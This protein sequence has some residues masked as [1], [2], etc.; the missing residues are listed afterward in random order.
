MTVTE[1]ESEDDDPP[2]RQPSRKRNHN[3]DF[4]SQLSDHLD[5]DYQLEQADHD[6]KIIDQTSH[7]PEET[8][9]KKHR[10]R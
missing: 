1:S 6:E 4:S 8:P 9:S 10:R 3:L 2:R 7:S 5:K